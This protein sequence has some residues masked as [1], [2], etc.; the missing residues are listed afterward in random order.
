MEIDLK[1]QTY[2]H[3]YLHSEGLHE[4]PLWQE[5]LLDAPKQIL[6]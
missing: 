1:L 2:F 3:A 6:G 4:E 5:L